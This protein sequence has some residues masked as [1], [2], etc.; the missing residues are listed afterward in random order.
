MTLLIGSGCF[1]QCE[2]NW[3]KPCENQSF[4]VGAFVMRLRCVFLLAANAGPVDD[5]LL[6]LGIARHRAEKNGDL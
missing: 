1:C 4:V 6:R 3:A 2:I 5:R